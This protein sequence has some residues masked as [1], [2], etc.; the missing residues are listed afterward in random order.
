MFSTNWYLIGVSLCK[1]NIML[2]SI[3]CIQSYSNSIDGSIDKNQAVEYYRK[4]R[5][6]HLLSVQWHPPVFF[7]FS[8]TSVSTFSIRSS[9]S[10]SEMSSYNLFSPSAGAS[11]RV[12]KDRI[13]ITNLCISYYYIPVNGNTALLSS[14]RGCSKDKIGPTLV[15][16]PSTKLSLLLFR[17]FW[18]NF[19]DHFSYSKNVLSP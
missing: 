16:R 19:C 14:H 15:L 7:F 12:R 4:T 13:A 3:L 9:R 18:C 11:G 1:Y 6:V 2:F 8:T 17:Q 5:M 10:S